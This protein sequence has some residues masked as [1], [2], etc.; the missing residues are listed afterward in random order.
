MK[1]RQEYNITYR[2]GAVYIEIRIK[3]SWP[4]EK[5]VIYHEKQTRQLRDWLSSVASLEYNT[6]M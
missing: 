3:L 5:D 4:I 2:R 1:I 6:E